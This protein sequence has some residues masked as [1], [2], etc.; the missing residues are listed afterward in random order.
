MLAENGGGPQAFLA[1]TRVEE[2]G[3]AD[4]PDIQLFAVLDLGGLTRRWAAPAAR[5]DGQEFFYLGV[6]NGS[7]RRHVRLNGTA[8]RLGE[9]DDQRLALLDLQLLTDPSDV[10]VPVEGIKAGLSVFE[11]TS[12]FQ[13]V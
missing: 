5:V 12:V 9:R 6:S 10:E 2:A 7:T 11:D 3:E 1:S 4:W 8:W 13:R